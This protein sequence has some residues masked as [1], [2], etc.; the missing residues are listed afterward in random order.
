MD[1]SRNRLVYI[2]AILGL[3]GWG[4][5]NLQ[6]HFDPLADVDEKIYDVLM[7]IGVVTVLMERVLEMLLKIWRGT[8]KINLATDLSKKKERLIVVKE[9]FMK[10]ELDKTDFTAAQDEVNQAT[11]TLEVYR[12]ETRNIA[13]RVS[14]LLGVIIALSGFRV[15]GSLYD[16]CNVDNDMQV[17]LFYMTDIFLTAGLI[18]GGSDGLHKFTSTL[19]SFFDQTN[20][21]LKSPTT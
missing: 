18:S 10:G 3:V 5:F 12:S 14:L 19:G 20:Q 7:T 21:R 17:I 4:G 15:L 2:V 6:S 9:K 16:P 8:G 1:I 11:N 13:L